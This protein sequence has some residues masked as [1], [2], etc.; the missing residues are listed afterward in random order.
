MNKD[1]Y[2]DLKKDL[3]L[4]NIKMTKGVVKKIIRGE[5]GKSYEV[6][7]VIEL[8]IIEQEDE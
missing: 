3:I 5:D 6:E 1:Q 8:P 4:P 2:E 7:E